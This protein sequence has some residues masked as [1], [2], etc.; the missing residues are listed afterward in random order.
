MICAHKYN[1]RDRPLGDGWG[2]EPGKM[3]NFCEKIS[4]SRGACPGPFGG[5]EGGSLGCQGLGAGWKVTLRGRLAGGPAPTLPLVTRGRWD[6]TRT[7][8]S[9]Q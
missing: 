9:A 8:L 2:G 7:C 5:D 6:L 4:E 1:V 3:P